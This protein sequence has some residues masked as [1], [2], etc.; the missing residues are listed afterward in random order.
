MH[1]TRDL[2]IKCNYRYGLPELITCETC[3]TNKTD[4]K[5][6]KNILPDGSFAKCLFSD[7]TIWRNM[8]M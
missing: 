3:Q 4:F 5:Q 7:E 6:N 8:V 1:V 2:R